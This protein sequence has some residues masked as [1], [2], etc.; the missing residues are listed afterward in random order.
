MKTNIANALLFF[1]LA[2]LPQKA[3][4]AT[5]RVSAADP[6]SHCGNVQKQPG[7]DSRI[8]CGRDIRGFIDDGALVADDRV[9]VRDLYTCNP[10][11]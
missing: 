9:R 8:S 4:I 3:I 5:E 6:S 7:A 2:L 10:A 1:A 11:V